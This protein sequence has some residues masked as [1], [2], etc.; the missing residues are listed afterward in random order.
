MKQLGTLIDPPQYGFE[1]LCLRIENKSKP[2]TIKIA[3][4]ATTCSCI[5]GIAMLFPQEKPSIDSL[6]EK[7][8]NLIWYQY[9]KKH[10]SN[11]D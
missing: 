8:D 9:D 6:I 3:I 11:T 2:S 7:S 4:L 1:K 10:L 5:L